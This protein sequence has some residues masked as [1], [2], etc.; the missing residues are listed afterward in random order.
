MTFEQ[1]RRAGFRTTADFLSAWAEMYGSETAAV[2]LGFDLGDTRDTPRLLAA[3]LGRTDYTSVPALSALGEPEAV[4]D[5]ML[6]KFGKEAEREDAERVAD[7]RRARF[8]RLLAANA[9]L[10]DVAHELQG[11]ANRTEARALARLLRQC[12]NLDTV[13]TDRGATL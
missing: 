6:R 12:D 7:E 11:A 8:E 5:A 9:A 13:V 3:R 4:D 10:R 1:A 2:G